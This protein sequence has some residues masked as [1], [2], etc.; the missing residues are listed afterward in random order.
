M[1]Q[2][3]ALTPLSLNV[4]SYGLAATGFLLLTALLL[5]SW[6][7][8][9]QG[10][11]LIVACVVTMVWA[12]FL[13]L[14]PDRDA[15]GSMLAMLSEFFRY[16][17]WFFV[18]TGLTRTAGIAAVLSRLVHVAW[19]GLVIALVALPLLAGMN[20]PVPSPDAFLATGGLLLA[21]LGLLLLEQIYRNAREDGRA[22]IAIS[23][24]VSAIT[25]PRACQVAGSMA[26]S[27]CACEKRNRS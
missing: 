26:C 14:G 2:G 6:Q 23:G 25:N 1:G 21:L 10:G 18:L 8:R 19:I 22:A 15:A 24:T 16:G 9:A 5:T 13:A 7:G 20:A 11:R 12:A 17:A 27:S 3:S 4:V